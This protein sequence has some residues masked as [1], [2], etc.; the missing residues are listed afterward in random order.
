MATDLAAYA[1]SMY[2]SDPPNGREMMHLYGVGDHGGGPTRSMLDTAKRWMSDDVVYPKLRF[3][4]ARGFFEDLQ[5]SSA[6]LKIPTWRNEMYRE[7]QRGVMTTQAETKRRIRNAEELLLNAEK[8]SAIA[9]LF[10]P[11]YPAEEFDDAWKHLLF[12][13]F[14]DIFPGSGI[15]VNYV[16]AKRNLEDVQRVGNGI[17]DGSLS[18]LAAHVRSNGPGTPVVVFNSL[19]W[20]RNEVV[21]TEVQLPGPAGGVGGFSSPGEAVAPQRLSKNDVKT[22]L[23]PHPPPPT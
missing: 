15:A 23:Q 6:N 5:K 22:P 7:Y 11:S 13:D 1:A 9:T 2:E 8:F 12:D 16:D 20:P 10:G 4:S 17:L 19:A 18:E 14:H 3:G 21:V